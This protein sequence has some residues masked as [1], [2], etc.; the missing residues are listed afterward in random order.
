MGAEVE[1]DAI[2]SALPDTIIGIGGAG[3]NIL[4]RYLNTDW[5][6][7]EAIEPREGQ[8]PDGF[9]A[10]AIDTA[11]EDQET[12]E[13]MEAQV[14]KRI[15]EMATDIEGLEPAFVQNKTKLTYINPI[16]EID[17][18][19][20]TDIGLTATN[21]VREIAE[22]SGI[23]AWWLEQNKQLAGD[24]DYATGVV[25]RRAL[26]KALYFATQSSSQSFERINENPGDHIAI[27]VGLGGGTGSGMFLDLARSLRKQNRSVVLYAII[28]SKKENDRKRGNAYAALSEL[29]YLSLTGNNPFTNVVLFPF[30]EPRKLA[31][32]TEFYD[33]VVQS[34]VANANMSDEVRSV[35]D[36][37]TGDG[38][39]PYAPFTVAVPKTLHYNIGDIEEA[40]SGLDE[41]TESRI[42]ALETEHALYD[43]LAQ[44]IQE[45]VGGKA[46]RLLEQTNDGDEPVD[47]EEFR[48]TSE[49]V[50]ELWERIEDIKGIL[51][52]DEYDYVGYET[53][54]GWEEFITENE[55]KVKNEES[56]PE[57]EKLR[58][59]VL[60][61]S[62]RGTEYEVDGTGDDEDDEQF[63][64]MM[65][66]ELGAIRK[67]VN[68]FRTMRLLD[69][70]IKSGVGDA[71]DEGTSRMSGGSD[72]K[73]RIRAVQDESEALETNIDVLTGVA[74]TIENE[75][76]FTRYRRQWWDSVEGKLSSYLV[77]RRDGERVRQLLSDLDDA[78]EDAVEQ[79]NEEDEAAFLPVDLEFDGFRELNDRL[80]EMG[81]DAD[82]TIDEEVIEGTVEAAGDARREWLQAN[83]LGF[84][85]RKFT[86]ALQEHETEY[87]R[88]MNSIDT[89]L[90]SVSPSVGADIT[91][92]DYYCTYSGESQFDRLETQVA[93]KEQ[94]LLAEIVSSFE[95]ALMNPPIDTDWFEAR[96]EFEEWAGE[97]PTLTWPGDV[98]EYPNSLRTELDRLDPTEADVQSV[99]NEFDRQPNEAVQQPGGVVYKAFRSAVFEPIE[100]LRNEYRDDKS[101]IDEEVARLTELLR[102]VQNEGDEWS[103]AHDS[104]M[105]KPARVADTQVS[106]S[107]FRV[108]R[109]PHGETSI[110]SKDHI[111]ETNFLESDSEEHDALLRTFW[112]SI[113]NDAADGTALTG[114]VTGHLTATRDEQDVE[115]PTHKGTFIGNVFMSRA[116][117][118]SDDPAGGVYE[119]TKDRFDDGEIYFEDNQNGYAAVA[120]PFG[121]KWD[122]SLTTFIGGVFLDNLEPVVDTAHGYKTGYEDQVTKLDQ[123][124]RVR[125]VHGLD[126]LDREI[127]SDGWGAYVWRRS[128][129]NLRNGSDRDT[130]LDM[131]N[132]KVAQHIR[133]DRLT[134]EKFRSTVDLTGDE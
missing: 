58:S 92:A 5:I 62:R 43:S 3:K 99:K 11:I 69:E 18:R 26:S 23:R 108:N 29:E 9:S 45:N 111:G 129:F 109:H 73:D 55:A 60:E 38:P 66:K 40:K 89:E 32:K 14:N 16:D 98:T 67:R 82:V 53:L 1:G 102:I 91:D 70:P 22:L 64:E 27:I 122:V 96:S 97:E 124:V 71:L 54:E 118:R 78:I 24:G 133:E 15:G 7:E 52:S 113:A 33:A 85:K 56:I 101:E 36:S 68:L 41:F 128:L 81:I 30:D 49:E 72:V 61:L 10:Y 2:R 83:S 31:D 105:E 19:Y 50:D 63:G 127:A 93:N 80:D 115:R 84:I 112:E 28:P 114:L 37:S 134:V 121:P 42:E 39:P 130:F 88:C 35:L 79:I 65:Q 126:G 123:N 17:D 95:N 131:T 103:E 77:V 100:T 57:E 104:R 120:R 132:E 59:L 13:A 125:H 75:D 76:L 117:Q 86:S 34:I 119:R 47:T 74:E 8:H 116:C 6:L 106:T 25:R 48:L 20:L 90:L 4:Y 12:D 110:R 87:D 94:E 51:E 46:W 21:N 107:M 44:F